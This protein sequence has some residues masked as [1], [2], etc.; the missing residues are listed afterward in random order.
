MYSFIDNFHLPQ[1]FSP[2]NAGPDGSSTTRKQTTVPVPLQGIF[3][4]YSTSWLL[5]FIMSKTYLWVCW[6]L[7]RSPSWWRSVSAHTTLCNAGCRSVS[8]RSDVG[9]RWACALSYSCGPK[10]RKPVK[11]IIRDL[12]IYSS[13]LTCVRP[14]RLFLSARYWRWSRNSRR[15]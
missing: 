5:F 10:Q 9:F 12:I 11:S 7:F 15:R 4:D 3:N 13:E 1:K 14:T 6:S 8:A 2:P